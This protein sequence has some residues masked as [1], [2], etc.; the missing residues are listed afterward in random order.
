MTWKEGL[1]PYWKC[2]PI[3]EFTLI[4]L[5][6]VKNGL[7]VLFLK[8]IWLT[9]DSQPKCRFIRHCST[10][11]NSELKVLRRGR[12]TDFGSNPS[13]I[14]RSMIVMLHLEIKEML[15]A[16]MNACIKA[17]QKKLQLDVDVSP[18]AFSWTTCRCT[19]TTDISWLKLGL[20]VALC[21]V[22]CKI[23]INV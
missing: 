2:I 17:I 8:K 18:P 20:L 4:S 16:C 23:W 6:Q 3:G 19:V 13:G 21:T 5:V 12:F 15:N 1:W 14:T 10:Q 22:I 9:C 11:R 7:L